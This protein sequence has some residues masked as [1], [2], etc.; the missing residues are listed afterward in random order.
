MSEKELNIARLIGEPINYQ[1]PVPI[2]IEKIADIQE[3][4]KAGEHVW[5][6]SDVDTAKDVILDIDADSKIK[7]VKR[8]PLSDTE[9]TF[10]TFNSKIERVNVS[11]VLGSPDYQIL[12]NRKKAILRGMDKREEKMILDGVINGTL[13]TPDSVPIPDK[14]PSSGTS[15]DIYDV[16]KDMKHELEDEGNQFVLLAGTSAYNKIDDYDKEN[17][18]SFNY[19]VQIRQTAL[20]DIELHKVFGK[21][22]TADGG[23][24]QRLLDSNYLILIALNTRVGEGKPIKFIRRRINPNIAELMGADVDS[25]QRAV[26]VDKTPVVVSGTNYA[27]FGVYGLESLVA[28]ITNPKAICVADCSAIL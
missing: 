23:D 3:P 22:V 5:V 14:S 24:E 16:V 21:V 7:V 15:D 17:A 4:A 13:E 20:K 26:I 8:D 19:N 12:G 25:A 10:K 11:A 9:L 28:C 18:S 27:S 1:K 6:Y 2:T